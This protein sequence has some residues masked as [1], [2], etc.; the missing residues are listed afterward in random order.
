VVTLWYRCPEILLGCNQYHTGV[1][2]WAIGCIFGELLKHRPL[3]PGKNEL[4][5]LELI[6]KL[7]GAL[8]MFFLLLT[9]HCI[10]LYCT[11]FKFF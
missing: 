5:Q 7:L 1:D 3:L 2:M 10:D 4:N 9:G 11:L 6:F 8:F